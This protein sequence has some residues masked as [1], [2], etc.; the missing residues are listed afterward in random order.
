[1]VPDK[2]GPWH[3]VKSLRQVAKLCTKT[4]PRHF[5]ACLSRGAWRGAPDRVATLKAR[6]GAFDTMNKGSG[7]VGKVTLTALQKK[8]WIFSS[9]L[10]GNFALKNGGDFGEFFLASV[11]HK[12]KHENSSKIRGKFGAKFGANEKSKISGSFRSATFLT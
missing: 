12:M 3:Y 1:M 11:S 7:A 5:L 8:L 4:S 9:N 6:K 10:P 2:G